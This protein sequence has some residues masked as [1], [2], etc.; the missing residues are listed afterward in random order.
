MRV[1]VVFSSIFPMA[2]SDFKTL[3]LKPKKRLNILYPTHLQ[4]LVDKSWFEIIKYSIQ[5]FIKYSNR[6]VDKNTIITSQ[7]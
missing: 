3:Y 7:R 5:T 6:F 2:I 1:F 4:A